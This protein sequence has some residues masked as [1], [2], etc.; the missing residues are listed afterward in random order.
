VAEYFTLSLY[1][2]LIHHHGSAEAGR[3]RLVGG[4]SPKHKRIIQ[5]AVSASLDRVITIE[6][7]ASQCGISIGHFARAF[8]QSFGTS[9]HKSLL[10][11][12]IER[13]KQ[14]LLD[15]DDSLKAIACQVGYADQRTFTESFTRVV[16]M[17][18]GRYRRRFAR[19]G[20]WSQP[21][22]DFTPQIQPAEFERPKSEF[23]AQAQRKA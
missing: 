14:L 12:R 22:N 20:S 3:E 21:G 18:P 6:D 13:G 1:S 10:E 5:E 19:P 4:L 16:G 7:I 11:S 8:R 23:R 2:H 15:T 9:F 17:A